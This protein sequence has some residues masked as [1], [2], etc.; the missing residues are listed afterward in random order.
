M[1]TVGDQIAGQ[2]LETV[3]PVNLIED[4]WRRMESKVIQSLLVFDGDQFLGLITMTDVARSAFVLGAYK[5]EDIMT[6]A[7]KILFVTLEDSL[8]KCRDLME[9]HQIHHLV[10]KNARGT[11]VGVISAWDLMRVVDTAREEAAEIAKNLQ[12]S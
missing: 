8:S 7:G 2:I 6:P 12:P 10:V 9:S 3:S 5:V 4:A 1:K 11:V